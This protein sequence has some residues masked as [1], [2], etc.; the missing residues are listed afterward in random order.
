MGDEL[1]ATERAKQAA[2]I[3]AAAHVHSGMRVGLGTGST[4]AWL[5]KELG[6]RCRE[7]GL[8]FVA[9]PTSSRTAEQARSEGITVSSLNETG[10]L[11]L[12]IDGA[13]EVDPQMRLIKGGGGAHLQEKIVAASSARMV[14]IADATKHVAQLGAFPLP[15]EV[16]AFGWTITCDQISKLLERL[17]YSAPELSLRGGAQTPFV[18]DEGNYILDLHLQAIP[19]AE[20][21]SCDLN[22]LP[23]VVENGLFLS[24]CSEVITGHEDGQVSM[25]SLAQPASSSASYGQTKG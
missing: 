19:D 10:A 16:L 17:G 9:V 14:V 13:D 2:A 1:S 4:A 15:V 11:D 22:Q 6:R 3:A 12:T 21:L 7:E 24:I 25:T 20:T 18:T 5:V 23:G 8:D